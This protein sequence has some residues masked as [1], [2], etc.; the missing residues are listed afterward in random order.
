M[1]LKEI[2]SKAVDCGHLSKDRDLWWVVVGAKTEVG[3]RKGEEFHESL[4]T[5]TL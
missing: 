5:V 3:F 2:W 1:Y 4:M